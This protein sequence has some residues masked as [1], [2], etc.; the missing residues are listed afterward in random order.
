M[1]CDNILLSAAR[2]RLSETAP[3]VPEEVTF[4]VRRE[5]C[6]RRPV[7]T[8]WFKTSGC[9]QEFRGRCVMCN[10]GHAG[11]HFSS[12]EMVAAVRCGLATIPQDPSQV[13]LVSPSG[14]MLD[15]REVPEEARRSILE[16]V[17]QREWSTFI[18]E[19]RPETVTPSAI[20]TMRQQLPGR[21]LCVEMGL[22]SATP[23]VLHHCLNKGLALQDFI[24]AVSLLKEHGIES[25][26]NVL[27]GSPFLDAEEAIRD[28]VATVHWAFRQGVNECVLFPV[29]V[30]QGTLVDWL[31]RRGMYSP[32]SLWSLVEVLRRLGKDLASRV[33]ISWYKA[34]QPETS[35]MSAAPA[36]SYGCVR[37]PTTCEACIPEVMGLLDAYRSTGDFDL[38]RRL[39]VFSCEC[40]NPWRAILEIGQKEPLKSRLLS[41][42]EIIG[43][44]FLGQ[45][46]WRDKGSEVVSTLAGQP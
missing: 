24:S 44:E 8:L 13:L 33:T 39:D 34:Y 16:L 6:F 25:I 12:E 36:A 11:R 40:K 7:A 22:E 4:S 35:A 32:P 43:N 18:C 10:Y 26:A 3:P 31:W 30:K 37:S 14:S 38:I 27:L 41:A 2:R 9:E 19:T 29:H 42:Y 23:L 1:C 46:W 15:N 17:G 5:E 21:E 45:A 20:F 28:A